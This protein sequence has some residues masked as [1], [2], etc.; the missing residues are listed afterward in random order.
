MLELLCATLLPCY[1]CWVADAIN[2]APSNNH[3]Q[4]GEYLYLLQ[5]AAFALGVHLSTSMV[6][7]TTHSSP[8]FHCL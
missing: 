2:T 6:F 3:C 4:F 1:K 5:Q 7:F 8:A